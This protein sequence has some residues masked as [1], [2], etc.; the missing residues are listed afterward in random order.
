LPQGL[1]LSTQIECGVQV[2]VA[3]GMFTAVDTTR[4]AKGVVECDIME[5]VLIFLV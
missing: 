3:K 4:V 2:L 5:L 1:I